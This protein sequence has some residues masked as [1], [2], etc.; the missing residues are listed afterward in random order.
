MYALYFFI[1][2]EEL[3]HN[4]VFLEELENELEDVR[5]QIK[6]KTT[7]LDSSDTKIGDLCRCFIQLDKNRIFNFLQDIKSSLFCLFFVF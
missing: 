4:S 1:H 6:E 5:N 2:S 7:V 3:N